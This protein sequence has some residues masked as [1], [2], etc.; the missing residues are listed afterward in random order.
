[1]KKVL[2]FSTITCIV[3]AL[4]GCGGSD[5]AS[6]SNGAEGF[7][8]GDTWNSLVYETVTS[9]HTGRVW[10]DRNLGASQACTALDD[11]ACYGDYYQWG[12]NSDG[13]EDSSSSVTATLAT[14]INNSGSNFITTSG[15]ADWVNVGVDDNG[16][17][18]TTQWSSIDGT[19]VC[20]V[21]FRVPTA[22]EFEAEITGGSI[23]NTA[24]AFSSFLKIP[25]AGFRN[26]SNATI[27]EQDTRA[28]LWTSS[29]DSIYNINAEQIFIEAGDADISQG[30]RAIGESV[31][32]I[33]D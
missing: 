33:K 13:H 15:P 5:D 4:S 21:G 8:S 29:V 32:C 14:D 9:P 27:T 18:R 26:N 12:R 28:M 1:M 16:S 23:G 3:F 17:L 11:T 7:Q 20:P 22:T 10:L 30:Y 6:P 19:S 2:K 31:R 25:S 24:D